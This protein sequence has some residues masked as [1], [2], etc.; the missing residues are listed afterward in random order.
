MATITK[1]QD[2]SE[3]L[4]RGVHQFGT[5]TFK[6]AL[7]NTAPSATNTQLSNITQI[8]YTNL[9]GG[10]APTV[11]ITVAETS[12]TTTVGG[13]QVVFTATGALPTFQYLILYNDTATN[14]NLVDFWDNG[15]AITLANAGETFTWKF[16]NTASNGTIFTLA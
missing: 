13:D 6:L 16:N 3:Q 4:V 2:F 1:I 7:S 10:V 8:A 9:L 11:T 14:K 12:G 5:H 15:T